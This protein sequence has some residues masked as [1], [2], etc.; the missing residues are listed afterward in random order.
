VEHVVAWQFNNAVFTL[1]LELA[2]A[3][4]LAR[5]IRGQILELGLILVQ[6]SFSLL[7]L[8]I[9]LLEFVIVINANEASKSPEAMVRRS[10]VGPECKMVE[11]SKY[12]G[13]YLPE[14]P[15]LRSLSFDDG[16]YDR[17]DNNNESNT[18]KV[19][20]ALDYQPQNPADKGL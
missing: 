3:A 9:G 5:I 18:V 11:H 10:I 4:L 1:V 17:K 13:N 16:D 19:D 6:I 20:A 7:V 8:L 12:S 15:H 2:D 14:L